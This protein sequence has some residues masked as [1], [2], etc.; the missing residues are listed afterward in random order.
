MLSTSGKRKY[1]DIVKMILGDAVASNCSC[2]ALSKQTFRS[3][4]VG[5]EQPEKREARVSVKVG[6]M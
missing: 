4:T 1:L 3:D 5:C 6:M 2:S